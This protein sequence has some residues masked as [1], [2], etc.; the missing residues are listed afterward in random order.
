[1]TQDDKDPKP[2]TEVRRIRQTPIPLADR[3]RLLERMI[4]RSEEVKP[5]RDW[6]SI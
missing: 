1:M 3:R 2:P 4:E 5:I 6:A